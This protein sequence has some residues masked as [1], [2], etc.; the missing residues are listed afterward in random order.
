MDTPKR[1]DILTRALAELKDLH[2]RQPLDCPGAHNCPTAEA[3]ED[4][5]LLI[6]EMTMETTREAT[7]PPFTV[8]D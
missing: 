3:I 5:E 1:I 6:A 2:G 7:V 4:L 8:R